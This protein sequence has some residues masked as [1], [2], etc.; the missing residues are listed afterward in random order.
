MKPDEL[1]YLSN[2]RV[3][4]TGEGLIDPT[5]R[6]PYKVGYSLL[7]TP[8]FAATSD[9]LVAFEWVQRLNA[10]LL[11]LLYPIAFWWVG[12]LRTN[13]SFRD[14]FLVANCVAAYPAAVLYATTAMGENLF[15]PLYFGLIVAVHRALETGRTL[16]WSLVGLL[17][18]WLYWTH[19]RAMVILALV[20]LASLL[21]AARPRR[22]WRPLS[23]LATSALAWWS[24]AALSPPGS[25][26]TT[27]E[28]S[29]SVVVRALSDPANLLHTAVGQSWY[30]GLASF[31]VLFLGVACVLVRFREEWRRHPRAVAIQAAVVLA[32]GTVFAISVL[33]MAQRHVVR[34]THWAYGRY[35]EGVLIPLLVVA[36]LAIRG[37]RPKPYLR[38]WLE[39]ASVLGLLT[40]I[41][42][43]LWAPDMEMPYSFNASSMPLFTWLRGC[44]LVSAVVVL[45]GLYSALGALLARRWR[46]GVALLT[47]L[48]LVSLGVSYQGNWV[49]RYQAMAE[50]RTLVDRLREVGAAA[51][52][53]AV[54]VKSDP[55]HYHYFQLG[56]FLPELEISKFRLG[57]SRPTADLVF[58]RRRGFGGELPGAR[59][60]ALENYHHFG[61]RR[62]AG[63]WVLPGPRLD[64][65]AAERRL[66][67]VGF[68]APLDASRL[69]ADFTLAG[70]GA[71]V[72]AGVGRR[73]ELTVV[74]RG[75]VPWPHRGGWKQR[76]F[77]VRVVGHWLE[78]PEALFWADLLSMAYPGDTVSVRLPVEAP[79]EW[80]GERTLLVAVRQELP[81]PQ[82][83]APTSNWTA[84][85]L[86]VRPSPPS[87]DSSRE[88][89]GRR[90]ADLH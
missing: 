43:A 48:F 39:A 75:G 7:L 5:H 42:R 56:Y 55:Y 30:L 46:F 8:I 21:A 84:L 25:R 69:R 81:D 26:W 72:R 17:A 13:W 78:E 62:P 3:L 33:F 47:L 38:C 90:P 53:L 19:E 15:M 2:A 16:A 65:L 59:L 29:A 54:D 77:S 27:G 6:S 51:G 87:G 1:G 31:G 45:G 10:L 12:M 50:Q 20:A 49:T 35:N 74:N 68:P 41:L 18:S 23:A 60:F 63:L 32:A 52:P 73:L 80:E 24:L 70:E 83:E 88:E 58:S 34:A 9:P 22:S 28:K 67:P 71:E 37:M 66:L 64:R 82:T 57:E 85:T 14:R 76:G 79:H 86:D 36:L 11:S 61:T 44:G 89:T 40:A 4:A